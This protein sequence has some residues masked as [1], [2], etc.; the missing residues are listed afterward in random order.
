MKTRVRRAAVWYRMRLGELRLVGVVQLGVG[1][2]KGR[3]LG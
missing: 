1:D 3:R 2:L